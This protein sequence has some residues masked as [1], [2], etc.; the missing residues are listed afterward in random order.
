MEK[1]LGESGLYCEGGT[2]SVHSLPSSSLLYHA[3]LVL[4]ACLN[5]NFKLP[6]CAETCSS[7]AALPHEMPRHHV[8]C[9]YHPPLDT[10]GKGFEE[11]IHHLFLHIFRMPLDG[12]DE[13]I[14]HA[15]SR[16]DD[17]VSA[18][19]RDAET[20]SELLDSFAMARIHVEPISQD[21]MQ[22]AF[23]IDLY[24][25]GRDVSRRILHM[26]DGSLGIL[27]LHVLPELAAQGDIQDLMAAA[28][29]EDRLVR[30]EAGLDEPDLENISL[31]VGRPDAPERLFSVETR[32]GIGPAG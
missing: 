17:A 26:L 2:E 19:C 28:D 27:C 9:S 13:V 4:Q 6:L 20:V 11:R 7:S 3:N 12:G 22:A 32:S 25:M 15:F 23:R 21:I 30:F 24:I 14:L 31:L 18:S 1:P 16:F 5:M 10:F 29:A 8:S